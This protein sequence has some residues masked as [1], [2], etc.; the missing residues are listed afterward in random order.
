MLIPFPSEWTIPVN[1]CP[2][3]RRLDKGGPSPSPRQAC[4]SDPQITA[5]VF[6]TNIPP[7]SISGVGSDSNS[8]GF[9]GSVK[10]VV[11]PLGI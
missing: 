10:T 7:G 6:L 9:P 8:N 1:S 3:T 5:S 2:T 4:K 11:R